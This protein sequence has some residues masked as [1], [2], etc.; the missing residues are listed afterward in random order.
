MH[1]TGPRSWI[2]K[3]YQKHIFKSFQNPFAWATAPES[4]L[5]PELEH[6]TGDSDDGLGLKSKGLRHKV[7]DLNRGNTCQVRA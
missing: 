7:G 4:L 3:S 5:V 6:S 1:I 2:V